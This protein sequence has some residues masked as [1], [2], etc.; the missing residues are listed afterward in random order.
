LPAKNQTREVGRRIDE[1]AA[2]EE[3]GLRPQQVDRR[4]RRA[5]ARGGAAAERQPDVPLRA[6]VRP[7]RQHAGALYR[8]RMRDVE[9]HRHE[10]AGGDAGDGE[11]R[12][13]AE[14]RQRIGGERAAGGEKDGERETATASGNGERGEEA[15]VRRL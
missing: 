13:G 8:A 5:R 9:L 14:R 10:R 3:F 4:E 1:P 7:A 12:L 15:H 6:I 2:R 11:R